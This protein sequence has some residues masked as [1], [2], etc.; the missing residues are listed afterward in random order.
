MLTHTTPSRA[1]FRTMVL[2]SLLPLAVSS[3]HLQQWHP[4]IP[5]D[6]SFNINSEF[7]KQV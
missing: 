3:Q 2:F 7:R 1:F 6:I 4:G 5:A